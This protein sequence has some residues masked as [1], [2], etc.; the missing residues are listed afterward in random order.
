MATAND[1]LIMFFS[2]R[3]VGAL[4]CEVLVL[5]ALAFRKNVDLLD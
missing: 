1:D 5:T 4:T 3:A 2:L